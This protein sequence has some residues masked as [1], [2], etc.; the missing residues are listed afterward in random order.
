VWTEIQQSIGT[1]KYFQYST[2][3]SEAVRYLNTVSCLT[4]CAAEGCHC[5]LHSQCRFATHCLL[6]HGLH[7]A[8]PDSRRLSHPDPE[9]TNRTVPKQGGH[10]LCCLGIT[11][12]TSSISPGLGKYPLDELQS[13]SLHCAGKWT[14]ARPAVLLRL[15]KK[16]DPG[17]CASNAHKY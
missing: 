10:V 5:D 1:S 3:G 7:H 6:H 13:I 14:V 16:M 17:D 11:V 15:H 9:M 2:F 12:K 4:Q 8:I